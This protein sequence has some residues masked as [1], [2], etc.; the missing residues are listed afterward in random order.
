MVDTTIFDNKTILVT[1][2]SGSIGGFLVNELLKTKCRSIRVLSNNEHELFSQQFISDDN[3]L[4][5]LLGDI[6]DKERMLSATE[7]T[8]FVFHA[9]ALKHLPICEYNPFDAVQ[10][11]IIGTQNV[12][13]ASIHSKVERFIFISTDKAT[14]PMSTLGATKLLAE[15]LAISTM[16]I[17]RKNTTILHCV[18]FGNVL[19]TRGS[20]YHVFKNQI[21]QGNNLTITSP[22]MTRFTMTP[23]IAVDLI[24][25]TCQKSHGGEIF[26]LKMKSMKILDL[27]HSMIEHYGD[28]MK[29]K[30]IETGM[31][32]GEKLHEDL[33]TLEELTR[34]RDI[35]NMIVIPWFNDSSYEDYPKLSN[36]YSSKNIELMSKDEI[37]TLLKELD[38]ISAI[39]SEQLS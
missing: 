15:R 29:N 23:K 10:T 32:S 30:I 21:K 28:T 31:R 13:E 36:V 3:R 7:G 34:A 37:K 18:R 1:G 24:L 33:V 26:V 38:E 5:F 9:A 8:D 25:S 6:R 20:V 4:R 2:G 11:N 22:E 27:A 14:S 39:N 19:G 16:N 12:I 17:G 35:D